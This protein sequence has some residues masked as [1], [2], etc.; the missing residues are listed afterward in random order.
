MWP[1]TR[2][3]D[4]MVVHLW[5]EKI[6]WGVLYNAVDRLVSLVSPKI[7]N[8]ETHIPSGCNF[9]EN[10]EL[11]KTMPSVMGV[12]GSCY[13]HAQLRILSGYSSC[14]AAL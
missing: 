5:A 12:P 2:Y 3:V 11:T 14:I 8:K 9:Q 7:G 1:C 10:L 13:D 4:A 6:I